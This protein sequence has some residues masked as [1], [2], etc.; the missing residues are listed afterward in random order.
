[1]PSTLKNLQQPSTLENIQQNQKLLG[2][3]LGPYLERFH[4]KI[5][6][7]EEVDIDQIP[8]TELVGNL[9][10]YEMRLGLMGKGGKSRNLSHQ[11]IEEEIDNSEDEDESKDEDEDDDEDEVL[12]FIANEI[13][14]L[15]QYRKKDKDKPYRKSKS[16]RKGKSEK[17][18]IQCHECKGFGHMRI[19]CLK[20]LMNEKTKNSKDKGLVATLSDIENDFSNKY[21]DECGHFMAFVATI[22]KMIVESASDSEDSSN[23]EVPKKLTLQEAYDKLCNEFIKSEKTSHLYREE[24]NEVKT[25]KAELLVKINETTWLV[26]TLVVENTSLEEK[27]KNLEVELSQARIQIKRMSSAKLDDVL[28][29]QKPSS[30]KAGLG[31][32]DSF[33]PSSS[34]ASGSKT[35]FMP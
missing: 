28:S 17:P 26:E 9:Q 7:I 35:I 32:V 18:L 16:S 13:I 23:D 31:Y 10:T 3:S 27:H 29:A 15:F 22:D 5:T 30:H 14:K 6:T 12:T 19:E 8:L 33:G 1:M 20:Y 24:L 25:E 2:Q 11:G 4:T 21:V 34:T